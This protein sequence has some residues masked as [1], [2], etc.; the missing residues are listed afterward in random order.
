MAA[1]RSVRQRRPSNPTE[2][3]LTSQYWGRKKFDWNADELPDYIGYNINQSAATTD[4]D[5]TIVRYL[6][7]ANG[8]PTDFQ[9]IRGAWDGR[10]ALGWV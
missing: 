7:D 8:N 9:F 6:W 10:A 3:A 4:D 2:F 1:L 5:W